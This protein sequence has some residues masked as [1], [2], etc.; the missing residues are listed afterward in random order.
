MEEAACLAED[1]RASRGWLSSQALQLNMPLAYPERKCQFFKPLPL[2]KGSPC[3]CLDQRREWLCKRLAWT[4]LILTE[5]A[6]DLQMQ[7]DAVLHPRQVCRLPDRAT[8]DL[9]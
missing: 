5:E 4:A 7:T 8:V 1:V 6:P 2:T 9:A 3:V